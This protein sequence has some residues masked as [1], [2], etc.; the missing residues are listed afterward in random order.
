MHLQHLL[1]HQLKL[2]STRA[3]RCL[4][5]RGAS[6][7]M[8]RTCRSAWNHARGGRSLPPNGRRA[9][10]PWSRRPSGTARPGTRSPGRTRARWTSPPSA[11]VAMPRTCWPSF[12]DLGFKWIV[13]CIHHQ[14]LDGPEAL[15]L[16]QA[17]VEVTFEKAPRRAWQRMVGQIAAPHHRQ[18]L[19]AHPGV[20]F[21]AA[22][23]CRQ[24]GD[25]RPRWPVRNL[26]DHGRLSQVWLISASWEAKHPGIP[27]RP[28]AKPKRP[29]PKRVSRCGRSWLKPGKRAWRDS[30]SHHTSWE[31]TLSHPTCRE[32]HMT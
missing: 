25:G 16:R 31:L 2:A 5:R 32:L 30:I 6:S 8:A 9:S 1:P 18:R 20:A 27:T 12:W 23:C 4:C 29:A 22:V 15:A 10:R 3:G 24:N 13:M 17:A 11:S 14:Q 28:P 21:G 7:I 26:P 19:R